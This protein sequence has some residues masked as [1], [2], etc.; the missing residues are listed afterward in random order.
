MAVEHT[1]AAD[2]TYCARHPEVETYLRCGRCNTPICPRCL[3]QTPV[4]ARCPTCANVRR[5]PTVDVTTPFLL[6]GLGAALVAGVALG[7][8]WGYITTGRF[9]L[10]LIILIGIGLGWAMTE[11]IGL[12]TNRK[13]STALAA[14]AVAGIVVAF[15]VRNVGA[16]IG[17]LPRDDLWG[18]VAAI[19]AAFYASSRLR[20]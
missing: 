3:V 4:G 16:D 18:Y 12:A 9:G 5:V 17:L 15:L 1:P 10:F 20:F 19:I 14:C 7:A 13:R 11:A 2:V 6:R 8:A